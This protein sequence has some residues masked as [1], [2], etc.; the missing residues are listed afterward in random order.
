MMMMMIISIWRGFKC[1]LQADRM[2]RMH[3]ITEEDFNKTAVMLSADDLDDGF[4]FLFYYPF[5]LQFISCSKIHS[6]QHT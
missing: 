4:E 2:R 5:Y 1:I 6:D 3:G